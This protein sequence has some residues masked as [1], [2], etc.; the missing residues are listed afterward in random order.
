MKENRK[1]IL[2]PV[3]FAGMMA[4]IADVFR[5]QLIAIP[6]MQYFRPWSLYQFVLHAL[7]FLIVLAAIFVTN[8]IA[9][10]KV[11]L[12]AALLS[13]VIVTVVLFLWSSVG[14]RL[15]WRWI[16]YI[17]FPYFSQIRFAVF[18]AAA[19]W[20]VLFLSSKKTPESRPV[21]PVGQPAVASAVYPA[22]GTASWAG[23]A[24]SG[25]GFCR[26]CGSAM[27]EYAA[28]CMKCGAARGAGNAFCPHCGN[29]VNPQ[30]AV[31]L[32]CG[33][34]LAGP[35]IAA[36]ENAKSKLAAG[37]LGIFLGG[38]GI[39]NFYLGYTKKAVAQLLICLLGSCLIIGP[40]VSGIWGLVEGI[41]ILTGKIRVDGK[42]NPLK[43]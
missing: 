19:E 38:L 26:N 25:N 17:P 40:A 13:P 32:N 21:V 14:M 27:N 31:C 16:P 2:M 18:T 41:L 5:N 4:F 10:K 29:P 34:S 30:A 1:N 35:A 7:Y 3:L 12:A 33:G 22:A 39:H 36:G 23:G 6:M 43:E 28:V 11:N 42:G 15:L 37:L 20:G 8:L 24:S 9:G